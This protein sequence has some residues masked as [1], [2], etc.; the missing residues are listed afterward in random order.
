[1][2]M[3]DRSFFSFVGIYI[4]VVLLF[5]LTEVWSA[6]IMPQAMSRWLESYQ[7]LGTLL[8]DATSYY[9]TAQVG[10]LG[11]VS[12]SIGLVTL[13]AQRQ[14]ARREVQIYYHES[15]AQ[16][17]FAS[18]I[19]LLVMLCLQIFWPTQQ[20]IR[21]LGIGLHSNLFEAALT[22]VH[23][24]WLA[25]NLCALAYFVDISLGF[26]RPKERENIRR[27]YTANWVIPNDLTQRLLRARYTAASLTFNRDSYGQRGP[28]VIFGYELGTA[29]V[30]ELEDNFRHPVL[31][32]D[33]RI[34]L[35]TWIIH[36]WLDRCSLE[37]KHNPDGHHDRA[38]PHL[39]LRPSFDR[40][41]SGPV[42]WCTRQGGVSFTRFERLIVRWSFRFRRASDEY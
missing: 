38:S 12:I 15:L 26:V 20:L 36:R 29:D 24:A 10:A 17:V 19:A 1:M 6:S 8:R 21:G 33:V 11:V 37:S 23:T 25:I 16:E 28:L 42:A 9:I 27:R 35:L 14:N 4:S 41:M 13:I 39:F 2:F 30:I 34:K 7:Q 40:P 18:S 32:Y 5:S 3:A 22:A 31:L